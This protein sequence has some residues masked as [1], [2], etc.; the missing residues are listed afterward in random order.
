MITNSFLFSLKCFSHFQSLIS[1]IPSFFFAVKPTRTCKNNFMCLIS[2]VY[3]LH[4][5]NINHRHHLSCNQKPLPT[6]PSEKKPDKY[7]IKF[8]FTLWTPTRIPLQFI[9]SFPSLGWSYLLPEQYWGRG[10]MIG[11]RLWCSLPK[12][13]ILWIHKSYLYCPANS[14][15]SDSSYTTSCGRSERVA[16]WFIVATQSTWLWLNLLFV[17]S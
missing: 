7:P 14:C 5:T 9:I 6:S 12:V 2:P 8:C 11:F 10:M 16:H 4:K 13:T 17:V 15:S 3:L 1:A